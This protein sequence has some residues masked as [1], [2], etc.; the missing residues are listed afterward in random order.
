MAL[1]KLFQTVK[2]VDPDY[3]N[4]VLNKYRDISENRNFS[5]AKLAELR[6]HFEEAPADAKRG[7]VCVVACG[8]Y[9]RLEA[10]AKSDLDILIVTRG[11]D[12][13]GKMREHVK[14]VL[15]QLRLPLPN[16]KGVFATDCDEHELLAEVGGTKERY[17][18]LSR[19]LLLLLESRA[20]LNDESYN[21]LVAKI[22][23]EYSRDVVADSTK[24][25]VY[26][27]N[28]LIRYF[29]TIC[30]NYQHSKGEEW[31][32]WPIRNIKLRH[33]RVL[34]YFSMV[35]SLGELSRSEVADK[36]QEL[37]KYIEAT[38]LE[39]LFRC[40]RSADDTNFFRFAG[41]YDVF[42]RYLSDDDSRRG[43]AQLEYE[44]RYRDRNFAS[45]KANSDAIAAELTRFF[46]ARRGYWSERFF[47]Y[48]II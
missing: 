38:P 42:L 24:N 29:R 44:D 15:A 45:L 6:K 33:S 36:V 8:S 4:R 39:R 7:I 48:M 26:L 47:E 18:T 14:Q 5:E 25:F 46:F 35:A 12:N 21:E 16:E 1:T 43:L 34:M 17:E 37:R 11:T 30:V 19:R 32:K 22:V 27:L 41:A 3:Q 20:L 13:A 28:D 10:S 23:E 2:D 31:G 9:A 40:Y